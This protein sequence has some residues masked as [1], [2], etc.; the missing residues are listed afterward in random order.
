[1]ETCSDF[2]NKV[3]LLQEIMGRLDITVHRSPKCHAK[4]AGEGIEYSWGFA[5][6]AYRRL[7]LSAK[8]SKDKF[9]ESVRSVMGRD[10][11]TTDR[12]RRFARR[13]RGYLCA[14]Y[15]LA[16]TKSSKQANSA[17]QSEHITPQQIEKMVRD[18][19]TH[20]CALDFEN[21][22]IVRIEINENKGK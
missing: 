12:D 7:P 22:F 18:F 20:R 17:Q 2:Q 13:A 6:N 16:H 19:K 21:K 4:L 15:R 3:T 5:K 11:L 1:M 14:Y 8:R 9:K 10:N